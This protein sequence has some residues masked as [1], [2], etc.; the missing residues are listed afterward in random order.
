[1]SRNSGL[2]LLELLIALALLALIA[3]GLAASM[4]LGVRLYDRTSIQSDEVDEIALRI[5]LR[6]LLAAA[7]PPSPSLP[8]PGGLE[9]NANGF[10]FTTLA[11]SQLF[12]ESAALR[13]IVTGENGALQMRIEALDDN[14]RG[15]DNLSRTLATEISGLSFGYYDDAEDSAAWLA[16]WTE[17]TRLPALVRIE[18]EAGS[19]PDWPEFTVRLRL[20][21]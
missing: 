11:A 12:P 16:T 2:S 5:R 17:T 4:G 19:T 18:A 21:G 8:F 20:R 7:E 9:G 3:G 10:A 6:A 13:V 15:F 14:G 1:M